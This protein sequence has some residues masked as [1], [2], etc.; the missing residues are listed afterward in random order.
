MTDQTARRRAVL[1]TLWL[2][3]GLTLLS[4]AA[5][6]VDLALTGTIAAHV[7]DAYPGWDAATVSM[8][9]T[10]IAAWL[11]GTAVLGLVGWAVAIRATAT[12]RRWARPLSASLLAAGVV[13]A[14]MNLGLGG[15]AYDVIVPT[16]FGLL[17]LLP[18]VAGAVA[19]VRMGP[20]AARS[21]VGAE[22]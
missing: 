2:G 16:G 19:V 13:V 20:A 5:P 21:A 14:A 15:D 1:P 17:S 18:T 8:D 11:V 6:L 12:G 10:A 7:R 9:T 22:A 4:G 3:A